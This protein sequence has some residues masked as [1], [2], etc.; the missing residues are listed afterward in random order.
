MIIQSA[1]ET[2]EAGSI[3]WRMVTRQMKGGA[4]GK[5]NNDKKKKME[6]VARPHFDPIL[7]LCRNMATMPT[8]SEAGPAPCWKMAL[9]TVALFK[10]GHGLSPSLLVHFPRRRGG[11]VCH[12]SVLYMSR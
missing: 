8:F 7:T 5:K 4:K 11:N 10:G 1:P 3:K 2:A 6:K 9:A 12:L